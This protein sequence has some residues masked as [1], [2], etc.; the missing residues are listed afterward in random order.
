MNTQIKKSGAMILCAYASTCLIWGSQPIPAN[1]QIESRLVRTGA[2]SLA[3]RNLTRETQKITVQPGPLG[4]VDFRA[5]QVE[6]A[7]G[8][9]A[10]VD[11]GQIGTGDG[12]QV[13]HVV[14]L[15][16]NERG[17]ADGPALHE[18]LEVSATGIQKTSYERAFLSK[19]V[20]VPGASRPGRYDIGGG[21]LDVNPMARLAFPAR[22]VSGDVQFERVE[23]ADPMELS[24]M[25]RKALPAPGG[26]VE[27]APATRAFAE[28]QEE[29]AGLFEGKDSSRE[30]AAGLSG[31]LKGQFLVEI[32]NPAVAND[33]IYQA[34][35]GWK[36]RAWQN[37]GNWWQQV[38]SSYVKSDGNW[39]I[40]LAVSAI[41]GFPVHLEFQPANRFV[42]I[43][44]ANG[45]VYTWSGKVNLAPPVTNIGL[46]I[47][48]LTKN[49][50]APGIQALYTGTTAV[51][52]KFKKHGMNALR[53]EPI[54]ITYPNTLATGKCQTPDGMGGV[55]PWSC[56]Y[57]A[58]G[59]IWMI[60][61]HANADVGQHEVGHSIHT[62]HWNGDSPAGAG[63]PHN[64]KVCYNP[65][66]ALSEGF[67]SF[68]SYW[69]QF[70]RTVMNPQ[71]P[72]RGWTLESLAAD[73]CKGASNEAWVAAALWDMYD[74][75]NDGVSPIA[76][77]WYFNNPAAPIIIVLG[78]AGLDSMAQYMPVINNLLGP[79]WTSPVVS[80]FWL[81]NMLLP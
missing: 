32:P 49:G 8:A 71:T 10:E 33:T 21:Y 70:D 52:R 54:E 26:A 74:V 60:A 1:I 43:Q 61:A 3:L 80:L 58:D 78:N 73:F 27:S 25:R 7:A 46:R 41:P 13:F 68:V 48:D 16:N 4:T 57:F 50:D 65:G 59:K 69:T 17:G 24:N 35:W 34:A 15:V 20:A 11:I 47:A 5:Q 9:A 2:S 36:V 39:T 53:D 40:D 75:P 66:L 76:D 6:L 28:R 31:V 63:I 79:Q 37:L 67:A 81:N 18:V 23:E 42:Q 14:S 62:F 30:R 22:T 55:I 12:V 51:W 29:D 56:S 19:R 45:V 72:F 44:D 64:A 77:T 38:G